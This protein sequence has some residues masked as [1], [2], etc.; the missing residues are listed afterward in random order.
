MQDIEQQ[1]AVPEGTVTS[2]EVPSSHDLHGEQA[3][4]TALSEEEAGHGGGPD[5]KWLGLDA[6]GWVS[7]AMLILI[8][9]MIWKGVPRLIGRALDNRVAK[10][11]AD[12]DEAQR[13]RAEAE[14][15]LAD[16]QRK[17]AEATRDAEDI[18][19]H[20]RTEADLLISE[21]KANAEAL[22]ARRTRMAED[23][24]AAA[25]RA[26]ADELRE[27]ATALA[28]EAARRLIAQQTDAA[29]Q[30]RLTDQAIGELDRRLH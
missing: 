22:V 12:L 11:K 25:E 27:R 29:Q 13:L 6:T 23:K 26:A 21:A 30:A 17:Q 4:T 28:T 20:A 7:V 24:I 15:L 10:I 18:L 5:V 8:G 2:T 16:Y 14:A 19:A 9:I 1:T 3:V